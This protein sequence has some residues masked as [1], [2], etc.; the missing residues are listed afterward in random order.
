MRALEVV[1]VAVPCMSW[2]M[3]GMSRLKRALIA[4]LEPSGTAYCGHSVVWVRV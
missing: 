2:A 3:L 4:V 1:S